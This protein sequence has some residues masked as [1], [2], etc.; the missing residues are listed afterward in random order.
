ML[1]CV[2]RAPAHA[3]IHRFDF[4]VSDCPDGVR[5][6][7]TH[8]RSVFTLLYAQSSELTDWVAHHLIAGAVVIVLSSPRDLIF[9]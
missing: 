4:R 6:N 9:G 5:D 1:S 2:V 7:Q 8:F 3:W